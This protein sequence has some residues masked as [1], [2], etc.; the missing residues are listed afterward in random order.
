MIRR[1]MMALRI[2][3]MLGDG[4]TAILVFLGVSVIRFRD[5]AAAAD[6]WNTLGVDIRVAALIFAATWVTVLW[7]SG[8][9]RVSVRWRAWTEVRDIARATVVVG[10]LTLSFLFLVKQVDVSRLFLI[11]LFVAQPTITLLG[12][13]ALRAV[14]ESSRARGNDP[15]YMLVAGAGQLAQDFADR[16]ESHP[17]LGLQIIGHLAA[18]EERERT[19]TRPILGSIDEIEEVLHSRVVDEVAVCLPPVAF[20]YLEPITGLAAGE[21]KTV[22]IAVNPVEEILPSG[23]QEEFDG[24]LVRSLIHD[25][26]RDAGLMVKRLIDIVGSAIG[27]LFLSPVLL[28]TALV[29]RFGEG[30]P[31]LF[32]QTRVGLHG[33]PFTIYKFRTMVVDAEDRLGEVW[34]L[35]ERQGAAFKAADDPR[36]TPIGRFLRKTSIDELPQLWNVLVGSMSLVGPR[37]PLPGEVAEYDVWHRRRLSMKPGITGLWQVEARHEPDFDRW[38]EHDLVYIDGWSIWLDVKILL[39]TIPALV[40]HGGH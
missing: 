23:I 33:R 14:F 35:N 39:K 37:P 12:R 25:G 38:V 9:Y 18:P 32:R 36:M 29:I 24:F 8:L 2:G 21:G 19:V 17:G 31:V 7:M 34:H 4:V 6:L 30:P 5:G 1:H 3:L 22:R 10:A 13:V 26:Q 11:L 28:I 15:R 40:M 16:V 27:L 20:R